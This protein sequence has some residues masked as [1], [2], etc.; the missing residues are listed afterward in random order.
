MAYARYRQCDRCMITSFMASSS[1]SPG[2]LTHGLAICNT[3]HGK[4]NLARNSGSGTVFPSVAC[5]GTQTNACSYHCVKRLLLVSS[6]HI[7]TDRDMHQRHLFPK[8]ISHPTSGHGQRTRGYR[9][10]HPSVCSNGHFPSPS[11]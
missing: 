5:D 10:E 11:L 2:R 7:D 1:I 4:W 3:P 9:L 6:C 8:H